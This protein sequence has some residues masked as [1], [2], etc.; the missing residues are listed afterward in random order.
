MVGRLVAE[1]GPGIA[2]LPGTLVVGA[3]DPMVP[4]ADVQRPL[5]VVP[6][7]GPGRPTAW[8]AALIAAADAVILLDAAE[9]HAFGDALAGRPVLVGGLPAPAPRAPAAG[10]DVGDA[11]V[12][13]RRAWLRAGSVPAASAAGVAW[14]SGRGV[15]P[16]AAAL[17]AWAAGRAVVVLPQTDDHELLRRGRALRAHSVAEAVEATRFL[18][19]TPPLA[20]ALGARGREVAARLPSPRQVALRVLEGVELARQSAP[21]GAR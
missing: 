12:Q 15:A 18:L 7:H 9:V 3:D 5:A 20:Q 19:A 16:L 1:L 11:P 14:V 6:A 10:L 21:A 2:G 13:V 8:G 4:E 17:E